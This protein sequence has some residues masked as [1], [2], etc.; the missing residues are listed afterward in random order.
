[1]RGF[2][3]FNIFIL[4]KHFMSI[5]KEEIN[6]IRE[7]M[8]LSLLNE[9]VAS[10][11]LKSLVRNLFDEI[12]I[13]NNLV[14]AGV[15]NLATVKPIIDAIK[16]GS[17]TIDDFPDFDWYKIVDNLLE[18]PSGSIYQK[19]LKSTMESRLGKSGVLDTLDSI[20]KSATDKAYLQTMASENPKEFKQLVDLYTKAFYEIKK[21][22]GNDEYGDH[23]AKKYGI[24]NQ[25]RNFMNDLVRGGGQKI[26]QLST[27]ESIPAA[28]PFITKV[29]QAF[30]NGGLSPETIEAS[31]PIISDFLSKMKNYGSMNFNPN[32]IKILDQYVAESVEGAGNFRQRPTYVVQL[33]GGEKIL[34][35]ISTGTGAPELK[36]AGEWQVIPGYVSDDLGES[37]YM[38]TPE[39]TQLTKGNNLYLTQMAK[40]FCSNGTF[41]GT[42]G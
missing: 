33:P 8:G 5:L 37:W 36:K 20:G 18:G 22:F 11:F 27:F 3:I 29:K 34:A 16:S 31:R 25:S 2:F 7:V 17:K 4:K 14:R 6:R 12:N 23:L 32:E 26:H 42:C 13:D 21:V 28:K 38:K 1:M 24:D 35:Y 30:T 40:Y 19:V 15:G 39:T 10:N 41:A 9:S